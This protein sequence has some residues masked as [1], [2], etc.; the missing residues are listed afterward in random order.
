MIIRKVEVKDLDTL[1][2]DILEEIENAT[3]KAVQ[4]FNASVECSKKSEAIRMQCNAVNEYLDT[5][6]G[7]GTAKKI[8]GEKL[9]LKNSIEVFGEVTEAIRNDSE[10]QTDEINQLVEKYAPNRVKR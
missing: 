3:E 7:E 9:N 6:F 10:T 5:L 4:K 2:P 1:N 8:F